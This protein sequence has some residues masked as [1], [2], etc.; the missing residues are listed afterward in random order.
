MP[1]KIVELDGRTGEGGGQIVRVAIAL[2]ALTK[3][4]LRVDHVR[5]NRQGGRGML[6][7]L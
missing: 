6:Q 3:T 1:P 5:G 4:P 7:Q 2:A